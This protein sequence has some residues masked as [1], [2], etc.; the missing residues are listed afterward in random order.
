MKALRH[1]EIELIRHNV[2]L[3]ESKGR[4]TDDQ[5]NWLYREKYFKIWVPTGL[6]GLEL[7]FLDGLE[8]LE[9]IA[10]ED[11]S[12]AWTVTL[13]SGAN[14]FVGFVDPSIQHIF[15]SIDIC[16]GGSGRCSG[17]ANATETDYTIS[18]KWTYATGAPH[19]TH[20]TLVAEIWENGA[21]LYN[22]NQEV[23]KKAFFVDK[24]DVHIIE[25]WNTF[26]LVSTASHSFSLK[27]VKVSKQRAFELLPETATRPE[28]IYHVPFDLFAEATLLVNYVGMFRRM[29]DLTIHS[30]KYKQ[31][32]D[33][34]GFDQDKNQRGIAY[35]LKIKE[36]FDDMLN[37]YRRYIEN[38]WHTKLYNTKEME[39][40]SLL[41]QRIV[42]Y[43]KQETSI[44]YSYC[45]I[46]ASRKDTEINTVFRNIFTASQHNL[47]LEKKF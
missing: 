6:G 10:Y 25:D 16:F 31:E 8:L 9:S 44:L 28:A 34:S 32:K 3:S 21:P 11:G 14:L 22:S 42:S 40:S 27:D 12:L 19:L 46:Y 41:A 36:A 39:L 5:L 35:V 26:G 15:S 29:V 4:L 37:E 7:D 33:L 24:A 1:T 45:G 23:I 30:F 13:C 43:I 2:L 17:I 38:M 18:G 47:L 20:F